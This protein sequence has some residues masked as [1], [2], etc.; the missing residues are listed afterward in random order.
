[1]EIVALLLMLFIVGAILYAVSAFYRPN[2]IDVI[3]F[4]II[5]AFFPLCIH[6]FILVPALA[7]AVILTIVNIFVYKKS[8]GIKNMFR[9]LSVPA[10]LVSITLM[11]LFT[12]AFASC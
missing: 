11:A 8:P 2:W 10:V 1:M 5:T 3:E 9:M 4:A 6:C 7:T 12:E